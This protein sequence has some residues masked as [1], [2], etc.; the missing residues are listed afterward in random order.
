MKQTK[1]DQ[2]S[3]QS[4][5]Q[6]EVAIGEE[7]SPSSPAKPGDGFTEAELAAAV[8]PL[9]RPWNPE[10][11]YEE[12]NISQLVPG[13]RAVTFMG[14][15]VH[16]NTYFGHNPK[17]PRAA[18][19]HSLIVKDD[20]AAITI[21]LYF[22]CDP[23]P[24]KLG[25]LLTFWTAFIS[26]ASKPGGSLISS[27]IVGTNMFP[28]RATSDHIMIHTNESSENVCRT[29]LEYHK[30]H[31]LPG[32]MTLDSWLNGGH[33]GVTGAK[34]LVCV[35]SDGGQFELCD[36]TVFDHTASV[37][38]TIFNRMIDAISNWH[39][40]ST[41]LL[42]T[43][44]GYKVAYIGNQGSAGVSNQTLIDVNPDF[45]DADWLKKYALGLTKKESLC[46]EFPEDIWDIEAAEYG[47]CRNLYTLAEIDIWVRSEECPQFT[48]FINI[49]I[50]EMSL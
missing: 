39:A 33:D 2:P 15:I 31:P 5:Y 27:I 3:I 49:T 6:K 46:L 14:R 19:F 30:T 29:P 25:Q 12:L 28:G 17:Q 48:G 7:A 26:D 4:F 8:D 50:M 35:K 9:S 32:L 45:A 42:I 36:V 11:E 41:I 24:L 20:S 47:V 43:N 22:A 40:G 34:I 38:L 10:R 21:K 44:P 13:P 16:C 37:K 23:Y 18:G 1:Q